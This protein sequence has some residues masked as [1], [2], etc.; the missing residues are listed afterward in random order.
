M[1]IPEPQFDLEVRHAVRMLVEWHAE[2]GLDMNTMMM[3]NIEIMSEK[4][5][6]IG[7][8]RWMINRFQ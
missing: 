2:T 4:H 1:A 8:I 7:G 3:R 6:R 5:N